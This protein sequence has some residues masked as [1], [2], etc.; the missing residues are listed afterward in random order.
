[1]C[2]FPIVVKDLCKSGLPDPAVKKLMEKGINAGAGQD[3][4]VLRL[5]LDDPCSS[6]VSKFTVKGLG[7]VSTQ[8]N[9]ADG[10]QVSWKGGGFPV[11]IFP[12]VPSLDPRIPDQV[13]SFYYFREESRF[14][15]N[16]LPC[17]S[18]RVRPQSMSARFWR[19]VERRLFGNGVVYDY[20]KRLHFN[21]ALI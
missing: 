4:P 13:A 3:L 1:V 8:G 10:S 2:P 7:F 17:S 21:S 16:L 6:I 20:C 15:W 11:M 18:T 14:E 9:P 5:R 12:G 19:R